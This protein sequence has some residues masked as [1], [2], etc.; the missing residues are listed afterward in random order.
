MRNYYLVTYDI[1][2]Q[3]RLQKIYKTMR[4]FGDGFQYSVFIF[5]LSK[6]EEAIMR[7][8]LEEIIKCTEDQVVIIQLGQIDKRNNTNPNE[9]KILGKKLEISDNSIMII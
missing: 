8:K 5:Q 4:G 3:R 2:D 1:A 6:K 7:G 9:W